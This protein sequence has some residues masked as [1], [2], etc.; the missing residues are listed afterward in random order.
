MGSKRRSHFSVSFGARVCVPIKDIYQ[1]H[2][3]SRG[4]FYGCMV[5]VSVQLRKCRQGGWSKKGSLKKT[6]CSCSSFPHWWVFVFSP[7]YPGNLVLP[8]GTCLGSGLT[9]EAAKELGLPSGIAVA[10]SLIDA[11]AGGLGNLFYPSTGSVGSLGKRNVAKSPEYIFSV[12]SAEVK[13]WWFK[14]K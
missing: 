11:H 2:K 1:D 7:V 6:L 3:M 13:G 14:V 8:P 4:V 12:Y 10:T 9:P 5:S